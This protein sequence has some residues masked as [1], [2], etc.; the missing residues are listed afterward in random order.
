MN[1]KMLV[2]YRTTYRCLKL[3]IESVPEMEFTTVGQ[4]LSIIKGIIGNYEKGEV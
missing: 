3:L 2:F 1:E 4:A